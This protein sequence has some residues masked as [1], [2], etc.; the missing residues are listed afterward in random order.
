[1]KKVTR[2]RENQRYSL[3][4]IILANEENMRDNLEYLPPLGKSDHVTLNFNQVTYITRFQNPVDKLNFYKD[5]YEA[6]K[7]RLNSIM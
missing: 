2:I 1:M 4:D 3:L 6:I 7:H 5:D